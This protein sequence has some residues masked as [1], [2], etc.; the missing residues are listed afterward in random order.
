ML[1]RPPR[2]AHTTFNEV[3]QRLKI[4]APNK[5][6]HPLVGKKSLAALKVP[7]AVI[8]SCGIADHQ[9][10]NVTLVTSFGKTISF[11]ATISSGC[12]MLLPT[13][14]RED[15]SDSE[16]IEIT[17]NDFV[18]SQFNSQSLPDIDD[19]F[20]EG[21]L[22]LKQHLARERNAKLVTRAK[23]LR[24][25]E[26]GELRCDVCNFSFKE[27]YGEAGEGFIEAHHL[28]PI[29]QLTN[30]SPTKLNEIA[31][32]CSNCHRMIHKGKPIFTLEQVKKKIKH[33]CR[34]QLTSRSS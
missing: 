2:K 14:Y 5:W 11:D 3:N 32:V 7:I 17:I 21:A 23:E 19:V 25:Q 34:S 9:K 16:S 29:S 20:P 33:N 13:K 30:S 15:I 18:F 28:I 10:R 8:K 24:L 4:L 27:F 31:L 12:E 22:S 26:Q 1:L 6:I